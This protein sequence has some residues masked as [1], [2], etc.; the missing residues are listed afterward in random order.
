MRVFF[1]IALIKDR[2]Q[3]QKEEVNVKFKQG[4]KGKKTMENEREPRVPWKLV[5]LHYKNDR[6]VIYLYFEQSIL[7][8]FIKP[9]LVPCG[10]L[11][12]VLF[13]LFRF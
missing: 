13:V 11:Q 4:K 5:S 2:S 8:F 7:I 1:L 9:L 3:V 12:R 10:I 6:V